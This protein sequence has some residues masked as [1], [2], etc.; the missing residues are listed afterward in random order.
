MQ[1]SV[2]EAKRRSFLRFPPFRRDSKYMLQETH[3]Q[4]STLFSA[5]IIIN[6]Q[7]NIILLDEELSRYY[8]NA[9][10]EKN[11]EMNRPIIPV[12]TPSV[13]DLNRNFRFNAFSA[14]NSVGSNV[15]LSPISGNLQLAKPITISVV[16]DIDKL[17]VVLS[18]DSSSSG[19]RG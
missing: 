5:L 1:F 3:N 19:K 18:K 13:H 15:G 10:I 11:V 4:Q 7:F 8:Y 6:R 16:F 14:T 9:P 2:L 12:P 17:I